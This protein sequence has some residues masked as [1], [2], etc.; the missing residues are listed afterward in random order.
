MRRY[1]GWIAC[2]VFF[3]A[4]NA[5][6]MEKADLQFSNGITLHDISIANTDALRTKGLSGNTNVGHGMLFV[7]PT[8]DHRAF[9]MHDTHVPL[10]IGFFDADNHLFLL[11][12]MKPNTE[13]LHPSLK[14]VKYALELPFGQFQRHH[15]AVGTRL[16]KIS[17]VEQ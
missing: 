16:E 11:T 12:D 9:W 1:Y 8:L 17:K 6:G 4:A 15:L 7:W 5:V 2:F 10:T 14:P 3:I 13:T